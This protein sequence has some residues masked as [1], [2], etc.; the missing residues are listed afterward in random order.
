MKFNHE[1]LERTEMQF[2]PMIDIVFLLLIFF[3]V[4]WSYARFETEIDISVPAAAEGKS[5]KRSIGEI[6][7]NVKKDGGIY[8]EGK[9]N[10]EEELMATLSQVSR[11]YKDQAVIL[12]GDKETAFDHIVSVLNVC[13]KAGIWNVAFATVQPPKAGTA[14][15][16]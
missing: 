10:S 16:S 11:E 9:V 12:R 6:I 2:A 13:Q 14:P 8:V 7:V 1:P 4:T 3:I 5:P 15:P